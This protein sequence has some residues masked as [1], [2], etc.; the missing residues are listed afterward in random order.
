MVIAQ[1]I[2]LPALIFAWRS[3]DSANPG[4]LLYSFKADAYGYGLEEFE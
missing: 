3:I 1:A 4:H 2:N